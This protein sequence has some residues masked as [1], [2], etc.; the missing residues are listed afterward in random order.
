M[1][2]ADMIII[3]VNLEI[4]EEQSLIVGD[5]RTPN[6]WDVYITDLDVIWHFNFNDVWEGSEDILDFGY[7]PW[8]TKGHMDSHLALI[9]TVVNVNVAN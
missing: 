3:T 6:I 8:I 4:N 2:A 5:K 9:L 1:G 7:L